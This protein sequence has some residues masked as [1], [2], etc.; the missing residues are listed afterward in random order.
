VKVSFEKFIE[1][2]PYKIPEY[3]KPF[4]KAIGS[5]KRLCLCFHRQAGRNTV[6]GWYKEYINKNKGGE[7]MSKLKILHDYYF[8]RRQVGHTSAMLNG[9]RSD[10]NIIVVIANKTQ[11]NYIELPKEQ[12]IT[13]AELER[14]RGLKNPL[15]IDHYALQVMFSEMN[16]ELHDKNEII[17]KL[18]SRLKSYEGR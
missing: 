6:E 7:K 8:V 9:A 10:K 3:M 17:E 2:L 14:L 12:M 13:L 5:N 4:I 15:L 11:K 16:K 1:S 18:E